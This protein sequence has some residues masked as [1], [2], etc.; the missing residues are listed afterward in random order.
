MLDLFGPLTPI[1]LL[2]MIPGITQVI[3]TW[4]KLE[5]DVAQTLTFIVAVVLALVFQFQDLFPIQPY[6][7][8]VLF[9]V[10]FGLTASGLYKLVLPNG[11]G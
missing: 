9:S 7:N 10:L 3:K 4:L 11:K 2:A 5:G 6:L 8:I 1:V